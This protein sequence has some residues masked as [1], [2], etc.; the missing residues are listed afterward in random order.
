MR[1]PLQIP[2]CKHGVAQPLL[3]RSRIIQRCLLY[4]S[5]ARGEITEA[6][7]VFV[8]E[9]AGPAECLY[10]GGVDILAE[11]RDQHKDG[12]QAINDAGNSGQQLGRCV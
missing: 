9:E 1:G 12:P 5:D 8:G 2:I 3:Q 11:Q 4:T 6:G 7:G 10:E